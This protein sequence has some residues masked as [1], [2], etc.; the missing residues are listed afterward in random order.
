MSMAFHPD[1]ATNGFFFLDYTNLAGNTVIA[2]Y[3]VS[4]NPNAADAGSAVVLL[5]ITQ[6]FA[7]HNGGQLQIGPTDGYLYIGMG[8]G[9]GSGDPNC[10]AQRKDTLLG[11]MLRLD[12]R[13]NLNQPPYYGIPA[14]NPFTAAGDPQGRSPTKCGHSVFAIRGDFL[15]IVERGSLHRRRRT[16]DLRR[17][18]PPARRHPRR[19]RFRVENHGRAPLLQQRGVPRGDAELQRPGAHTAHSRIQPR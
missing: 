8:D 2:R 16:G 6:P 17:D 14:S 15:S 1:Y 4:A 7:N 11:K 13:Q 10:Y 18:R 19:P 9:G 5:T 12:V 3:T